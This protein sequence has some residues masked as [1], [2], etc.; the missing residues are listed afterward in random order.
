MG[1]FHGSRTHSFTIKSVKSSIWPKH[2]VA[3]HAQV[4]Y[5]AN[6]GFPN[7]IHMPNLRW[8]VLHGWQQWH[9]KLDGGKWVY[10]EWSNG[11]MAA[12]FW[13]RIR[14]VASQFGTVWVFAWDVWPA[15]CALEGKK[16]IDE[17]RLLLNIRQAKG[18][19]HLPGGRPRV[20]DGLFVAE[21]PPTIICLAVPGGGRIKMVDLRNYGITPEAYAI[22]D[23]HGI[24]E[25]T[26]QAVK[27]YHRLCTTYDLGS[28][29]TTAAAQAWYCYRRSH[30]THKIQVH[31]IDKA[32]SLERAA[33][34]GGRCECFRLGTF[35]QKLYHLDV[36]SM[37]TAL[38]MIQLFPTR[39]VV[40]FNKGEGVLADYLRDNCFMVADVTIET[41][42]P[43]W[44]AREK[45][46]ID[47]DIEPYQRGGRERV[48]YPVGKFRTALCGVELLLAAT[49]GV[50]KDWHRVQYYEQEPIM[51]HWCQWALN[52]RQDIGLSPLRH[53]KGVMKKIMN[54]L[55]GKWGQRAKQW[56]D[57]APP[58]LGSDI[59]FDVDQWL[60]EWGGNP[61]SGDLTQYRTIAGQTQFL[62]QELLCNNSCPVV[63]AAWTAFGRQFLWSIIQEAGMENVYYCDTDSV[64]V[65]EAGMSALMGSGAVHESIPGR[66][67]LRES[68][69]DVQIL[70]IRRYRFGPRWC[71]AGPFG[72]EVKGEELPPSWE[73][74]EGFGGQLWH[75]SVGHSVRVKRKAKWRKEYHHGMVGDDGVVLPFFAGL[76][77]AQ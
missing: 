2:F 16:E 38:G 10:G 19:N 27:D 4:D 7:S 1:V 50:I 15:W 59:P 63:S 71:V 24:M 39:L 52:A 70:G 25:A 61:V 73:E 55:P 72:G 46:K 56:V 37:Y 45:V 26:V 76:D 30:M 58:G 33:Y 5:V 66:M 51:K 74:H 34:Y 18:D 20:P 22:K 21:N 44:P 8:G 9:G 43:Q 14:R 49:S 11:K 32:L 28:L 29:Q 54:A 6:H 75:A 64:I 35:R 42:I 17:G 60:M 31:P 48:I 57:L 62:S 53:L 12:E 40:T 13:D 67:K 77:A 47:A 65:N 69:D 68:S 36:N 41:S 3:F 23:S